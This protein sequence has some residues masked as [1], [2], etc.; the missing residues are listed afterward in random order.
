MSADEAWVVVTL[1]RIEFQGNLV[2]WPRF[3]GNPI[4]FMS[5]AGSGGIYQ[6]LV[7]PAAGWY[8]IADEGTEL[9]QE[10]EAIPIFAL[11]EDELGSR[12][13][14]AIEFFGNT[15]YDWNRSFTPAALRELER[16]LREKLSRLVL[17]EKREV[18]PLE[19]TA[20]YADF[21]H[22]FHI[23][24]SHPAL[25][26]STAW[27]SGGRTYTAEVLGHAA[28]VRFR[29]SIRRVTLPEGLRARLRL[30]GIK[31]VENGDTFKGEIF[32]QARTMWGFAPSGAPLQR[33][34]RVPSSGHYSMGDGDEKVLSV[35]LFEGEVRPFLYAEVMVW[36][37]DEPEANDQ[38]DLLG[39]FFGLWLPWRLSN[40]PGGEKR[41]IVPKSTPDGEVYIYLR[42]E[43]LD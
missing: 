2:M 25:P 7:W 6:K 9:A 41:L 37:E 38:H 34:V 20:P 18:E 4:G 3:K 40:L 10:T 23:L 26:S 36:D 11:P 19:Y 32:I 17:G 22:Y 14:T 33:L 31:T 13:G 24:S 43:L 16:K 1:D 21:S 39:G 30:E 35:V 5:V 29:Y 15:E 8:T 42:L 28:Q 12:L 27:S